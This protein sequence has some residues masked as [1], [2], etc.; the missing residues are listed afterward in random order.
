MK[1]RFL[2][3]AVV[4][5]GLGLAG[6]LVALSGVIPIKASSGHWPITEWFLKFGMHRSFATHSLGVEVPPLDAPHLVV[7]GA[8]HYEIGCRSCHGSPE[9]RQPRIAQSMTPK[10]PYLPPLIEQWSTRQLFSLVKH[11]VKFTGMP[12]WA[13]PERDDEVWAVVAFLLRMPRM[14]AA[15]YQRL[16]NGEPAPIAP[17]QSLVPT[18]TGQPIPAAVNQTC[19]RCHAADG[20]GRGSPAFPKIA[21]QRRD[22]LEQ[23]LLAYADD[24]RHSGIMGPI[25][26]GLSDTMMRQLAD[27][28]AQLDPGPAA[29]R[30]PPPPADA[31]LIE[32][33]RVLATE[34]L[35]TERIPACVE[36]H[37]PNGR[38]TKS[39]YPSLAGQPAA[40][41]E[42]Q[43]ELFREGRRGGSEY[44]HL[45]QDI[46]PRLTPEQ[47]RAVA[48][49][50]ESLPGPQR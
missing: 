41:L 9:L 40:Y 23:A 20:L 4:L 5:V 50:F 11:G 34:G 17:I 31:Q 26:A 36:C 10:A 38:R 29:P 3:A 28:Y 7:K 16:A 48:L 49:Y 33:G 37:G 25:S 24:R 27:Y 18:A 44:A 32:Q 2:Q 6:F 46:A 30:P 42:L 35:V 39:A 15:E 47:A 45:M 43:L 21:G 22:Y 13:A 1:R 19:V 14:D 12:A 8:T